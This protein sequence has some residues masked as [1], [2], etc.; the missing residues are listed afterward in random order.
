MFGFPIMKLDGTPVQVLETD[1]MR[2][3]HL[4]NHGVDAIC[5]ATRR[6]IHCDVLQAY[7]LQARLGL[8]DPYN[9]SRM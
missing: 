4:H 6:I 8:L 5:A 2:Y 9:L 7:V 3:W 1:G